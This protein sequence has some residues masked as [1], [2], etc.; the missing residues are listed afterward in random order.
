[1]ANLVVIDWHG[2]LLPAA[3]N[4]NGTQ[5]AADLSRVMPKGVR[6]VYRLKGGGPRLRALQRRIQ[7]LHIGSGWFGCG[8]ALMRE[9]LLGV[10][11]SQRCPGE[12]HPLDPPPN[13]ASAG[14]VLHCLRAAVGVKWLPDSDKEAECCF[15]Q[16]LRQAAGP[17]RASSSHKQKEIG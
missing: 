6:L 7:A 14:T 10:R 4:D 12:E 16:A 17:N 8:M 9:A 2:Y 3:C 5:L 13:T 15:M 1:M 11:R